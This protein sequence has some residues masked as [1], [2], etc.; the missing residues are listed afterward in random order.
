M[1]RVWGREALLGVMQAA[2][3]R[4]LSYMGPWQLWTHLCRRAWAVRECGK[5]GRVGNRNGMPGNEGGHKWSRTLWRGTK[6]CVAGLDDDIQSKP[7]H[8]LNALSTRVLNPQGFKDAGCHDDAN[9][10]YF[11]KVV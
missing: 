3:E 9:Q 5:V 8:S 2:A 7:P 6:R 11:I 4:E 1:H 10:T